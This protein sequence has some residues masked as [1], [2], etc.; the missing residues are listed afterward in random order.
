MLSD[1]IQMSDETTRSS[2]SRKVREILW[3]KLT[4]VFVEFFRN[5]LIDRL[6]T[7]RTRQQDALKLF[8]RICYDANRMSKRII[9]KLQC[10]NICQALISKQIVIKTTET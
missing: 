5:L 2:T 1:G 7:R 8:I 3:E 9:S 6:K 10:T 4:K